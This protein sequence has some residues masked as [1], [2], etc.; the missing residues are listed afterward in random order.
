MA[1]TPNF[2]QRT[3]AAARYII[4]GVTPSWFGPGQPL[5]PVAD[6]PA[7]GAIGRQFDYSVSQNLWRQPK[8]AEGQAYAE[9]RGM[10]DRLDLLRLVIETRKDQMARLAWTFELKD[11]GLDSERDPRCIELSQFFLSPDKQ[12]S[13]ET[14]LRI[15]LEDMLVIDATTLYPRRT[16]DGK[17]YS[18][19]P[20]D[21]ATVLR[22]LDAHGRTPTPPNPAYQ[23]I[24][25]GL[26]AAN[27]TSEELIYR[28]RNLRS[29][30]VYG[31]SPTEQVRNIVLTAIARQDYQL[32][33]YAD[34]NLPDSLITAPKEWTLAQLTEFQQYWDAKMNGASKRVA[35]IVAEGTKVIDTKAHAMGANDLIMNEWLARVI[36]FAFNVTNTALVSQVN[37][38]TS[39]SQKEVAQEDGLHPTKQWLKSLIDFIVNTV[40]GYQDIEF[41]YI[42]QVETDPLKKAQ[43]DQ[44]YSTIGVLTV[45]EIRNT[46]DM[47]PL[48][49]EQKKEI[50]A[51]QGGG[52]SP[53]DTAALPPPGGGVAADRQQGAQ[54]PK[55]PRAKP[56]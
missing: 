54:T 24:L 11:K 49:D 34:G 43:I 38:A 29:N 53:E 36:C 26:P 6:K 19:D 3:A 25:K 2:A 10:A 4:S 9:L 28:P 55:R 44:I 56:L 20:I 42:Q 35:T 17:V 23:Q 47:E 46:L 27:Y 15:I 22:L 37:R 14:W 30:R 41:V 7:D 21:G 51:S 31:L 12:N 50:Q 5:E 33:Y 1:D 52:V 40:F 32:G 16:A 45:D 13:W 18:I 8:R 48:T 39:D